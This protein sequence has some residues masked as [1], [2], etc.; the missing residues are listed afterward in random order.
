ML[1]C[2]K[3]KKK[4]P[5]NQILISNHWKKGLKNIGN[6]CYIN[7]VLHCLFSINIIKDFLSSSSHKQKT[8]IV[9]SLSQ[10]YIQ[11]LNDRKFPEYKENLLKIKEVRL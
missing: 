4:A 3:P 5:D 7:S 1:C 2:L 8:P 11:L 10:L 6:S 9:Y